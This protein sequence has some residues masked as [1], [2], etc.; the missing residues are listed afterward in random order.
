MSQINIGGGW[1]A[2]LDPAEGK[3]YYYTKDGK[4]QWEWPEADT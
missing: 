4:T 3:K 1:M 2:V